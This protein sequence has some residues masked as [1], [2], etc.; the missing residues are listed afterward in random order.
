[1][2]AIA[3]VVA[4][5]PLESAQGRILIVNSD[6]SV[7]RYAVA[8]ASFKNALGRTTDEIDLGAGANQEETLRRLI[9]TTNPAVVYCIGSQAY[10]TA[11]AVAKDRNIIVSS[12]LNVRRFPAAP[13][14]FG[15]ATELQPVAQMTM[16]RLLF[17]QV[18]RIGVLY[19]ADYNGEWIRE[20]EALDSDAGLQITSRQ[21]SR[22]SDLPG[23]LNAMLPAVD[24]LW[25][26]PDP[27]VLSDAKS[28]DLIFAEADKHSKAIFAYDE[29]FA[30]RGAAL[31]ITSD[32]ATIGRQAARL[33]E[34]LIEGRTPS[35][36]VRS[37]A[38]SELTLNQTSVT[39]YK[40]EL[41]PDARQSVN[42]IIK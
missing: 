8:H 9:A 36:A 18:R 35:G 29:A 28:I 21:V 15:I 3:L 14:M 4:I 25:L 41:N 37:P 7:P 12:A 20:A 38:G 33:A 19:S 27:V 42:N 40:L 34:D 39:K 5:G 30:R 2:C 22:S 24:V 17:P 13:K 31:A 26:I 23:A 16:F 1:M 32:V 11:T 10:L 6:R